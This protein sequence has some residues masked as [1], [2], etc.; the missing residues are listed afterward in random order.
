MTMPST[1]KK[2]YS[3]VKVRLT[4]EE[5][6]RFDELVAESG[7]SQ[8]DF[9][10]DRCL[11]K[12]QT[13]PSTTQVNLYRTALRINRVLSAV[14]DQR[15]QLQSAGITGPWDEEDLAKLME[16]FRQEVMTTVGIGKTDDA[17]CQDY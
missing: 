11:R 14:A 7:M 2:E 1:G 12:R 15:S 9:I 16:Q 4:Q 6:D 10:R 8:N 17:D 13:K 3:Q 5:R